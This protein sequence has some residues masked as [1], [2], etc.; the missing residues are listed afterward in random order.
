MSIVAYQITS[1][2]R[3][4]NLVLSTSTISNILFRRCSSDGKKIFSPNLSLIIFLTKP[5][6]KCVLFIY[7]YYYLY[8]QTART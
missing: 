5:L 7:L 1:V 4:N 6:N 3:L 2:F 8:G